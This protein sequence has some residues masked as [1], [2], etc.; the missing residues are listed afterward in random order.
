MTNLFR[1]R[2]KRASS[3]KNEISHECTSAKEVS[4][5]DINTNTSASLKQ[6]EDSGDTPDSE[7]PQHTNDTSND[8]SLNMSLASSVSKASTMTFGS[9]HQQDSFAMVSNTGL[10]SEESSIN[11]RYLDPVPRRH[12][13]NESPARDEN[14]S[15][16]QHMLKTKTQTNTSSLPRLTVNTKQTRA[17]LA[18]DDK[19]EKMVSHSVVSPSTVVTEPETPIFYEGGQD[20]E[21]EFPEQAD[22]NSTPVIHMP[23]DIPRNLQA[24]HDV[25]NFS[26]S[27]DD[28]PS[29]DTSYPR[30]RQMTKENR[31]MYATHV[32]MEYWHVQLK[33]IVVQYGSNSIQ[34]AKG[35]GNLGASLLRCQVCNLT[36]LLIFMNACLMP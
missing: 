6:H 4:A 20:Q 32:E 10:S 31:A 5:Q 3:V 14:L 29:F 36:P 25:S 19:R 12:R 7:F 35:M 33:E 22:L 26:T 1:R 18:S 2:S 24:A 15:S 17:L 13:G 8:D 11:S 28:L 27:L 9:S 21:F 23:S 30:E 16:G 34:A